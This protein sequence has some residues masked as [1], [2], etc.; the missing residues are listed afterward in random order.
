[1]NWLSAPTLTGEHVTLEPLDEQHT[2]GLKTAV[3]DGQSW[4]LWYANVPTPE[5]MANYVKEAIKGTQQGNVVFVVRCNITGEVVG[6]TR[7]YNVDGENKRAMLGFTWYALS[8]RRTPVNTECKYLLLRH[9]FETHGAIAVEFRTH[10][11]NQGSRRAIERLGAKQ[12]GIIRSHQIS[13]DGSVRDT[14]I[15]SIIVSEWTAVKNN[16]EEK[17]AII[18]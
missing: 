10:F 9:I 15:Y 3:L 16:L 2:N 8:V 11:F 14:V 6:T 5:T 7:F 13:K 17:L 18:R 1:M 4:K 12:D